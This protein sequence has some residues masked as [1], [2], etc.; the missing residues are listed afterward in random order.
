[1]APHLPG[2]ASSTKPIAAHRLALQFKPGYPEACNDLGNALKHQ[3]RL[4]EAIAAFRDAIQLKPHFPEACNNLGNALRDRRQFD[5]AMTAC[6]RALE[7]KPDFPDAHGSLGAAL[8]GRGELDEAIAAFR[9]ALQFQPGDAG[10]HSNLIYT[11]HFHPGHDDRTIAEEHQRWNRRFSEPLTQFVPPYANDRGPERRLRLGYVSP[12][13]RNHVVGRNLLPLFECHDHGSFEIF[14]Y[15]GVLRPD[16]L[17]DQIRR[18]AHAWRSTVGV[19]DE[20]LA[21]MIQQDGVDILVDLTQHMAGNRLPVFARRP[22]PVQISFAGYPETTGLEAIAYRISD[23]YL[24]PGSAQRGT[25][26]NE[27]LFLIDSFWCY[28]PG[29]GRGES[30]RTS[31]RQGRKHHLWMPE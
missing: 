11:L 31:R 14:C 4:K 30:Q 15:S 17:T 5:E 26:R 24:E 8:A 28:D 9:R 22:A 16:H 18:R 13:F 20:A 2:K 19:G 21:E 27:H 7:L 29:P 1:M 3:G 10:T 23:R 6:R 12:D 25:G